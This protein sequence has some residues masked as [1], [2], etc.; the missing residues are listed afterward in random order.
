MK[1]WHKRLIN[2]SNGGV[3]VRVSAYGVRGL[4]VISAALYMGIE[5]GLF[6]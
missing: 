5:T 4:I 3:V 1:D 6:L 2:G